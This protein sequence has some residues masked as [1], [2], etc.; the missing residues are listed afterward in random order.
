[1]EVKNCS[2]VFLT[3]DE[4]TGQAAVRVGLRVI[5]REGIRNAEITTLES[6]A[7]GES[8]SVNSVN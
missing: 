1:L 7:D 6:S 4:E 3:C 2:R 5:T 8:V